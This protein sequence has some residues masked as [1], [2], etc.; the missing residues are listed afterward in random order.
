MEIY[1]SALSETG[2]G[3][4]ENQD[5]VFCAENGSAG[6]FL[7]ADGMG[8][9]T[10][11]ARASQT[12]KKNIEKWWASYTVRKKRCD[13]FQITEEI[14]TVLEQS[15]REILEHTNRLEICGSTLVLLWIH[16]NAWAVFSCGDSRCYQVCGGFFAGH[17]RQLTTDDVWENQRQ[18]VY[19][20]SEAE[21]RNHT[22]FG[23]L[24]R[25]VGTE[26][27]LS[28]TVISDWIKDRTVFA[29]CSDGIYKY[30]SERYFKKYLKRAI[31]AE[32]IKSCMEEI[33]NEVYRNQ[34]PDNLSLILV[35]VSV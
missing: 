3:R 33:K 24:I 10:D 28:C 20:L 35:H 18:N 26:E 12:L 13:F 32:R 6:I 30:C 1:Y 16:E 5:S 29:L 25:A 4:K 34:A 21:I 15:N 14:K 2:L 22:N 11:G 17:V 9:H 19:G 7:L 23:R 8:G 27:N 31:K